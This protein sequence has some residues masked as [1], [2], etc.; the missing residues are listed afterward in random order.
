MTEVISAMMDYLKSRPG[1]NATT[2]RVG[3]RIYE[4]LAPK[5]IGDAGFPRVILTPI[6]GPILRIFGGRNIEEPRVQVDVYDE[7]EFD[8][9]ARALAI[10]KQLDAELL[11]A[12]LRLQDATCIQVRRETI[13]QEVVDSY[14]IK[15]W[16]EWMVQYQ[17]APQ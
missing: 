11:D 4:I 3:G 6:G 8:R 17:L 16:A 15:I 9:G 2:A 5:S 1:A 12:T 10:V 14:I 13:P 7:F